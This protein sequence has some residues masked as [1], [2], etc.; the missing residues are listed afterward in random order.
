MQPVQGL[1]HITAVAGD[2][3]ANVDF[4][5]HTLGQRLVKTTVNFDDPGTYHFYYG[6]E[7][8][9]PGTIMTFFPWRNMPRGTAGNGETTAVGYT[10]GADSVGFWQTHLTHQGA[11]PGAVEMRFGAEVIPF[12]DPDG[13]RLE[14]IVDENPATIRFWEEGPIPEQHVL[15]GFHGVTLWLA[16]VEATAQLLTE[17]LGYEFVAQEGN[18]YRYRSHFSDQG[19]THN[20]GLFVDLLHRPGMPAGRF[21]S[22]SIHHIAFRTVDDDEQQEYMTKLRHG[23]Q[24]VT[25]VQ[26]RQYFRSIYFRSPGGVLLE[27][28]TDAPGFAYDEAV[29]DLGSSLKLP[30]WLEA[31]RSKIEKAL[32]WIERRPVVKADVASVESNEVGNV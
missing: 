25:P 24:N 15:R 21:G 4:Y 32:P 9:T 3:Q 22:G 1:H 26:D 31:Q 17:Q 30:R 7:V 2:P 8:G 14:L 12:T 19:H 27:I 18:R 28:A 16:E 11:E 20:V 5:H 6:D 13:M 29:A 23:G 10:I